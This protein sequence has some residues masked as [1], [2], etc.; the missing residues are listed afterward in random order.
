MTDELLSVLKRLPPPILQA[1]VRGEQTFGAI[2]EV[3]I[4]AGR[5]LS[6]T[7]VEGGFNRITSL[8]TD[9][10]MVAEAVA[11]LC[12]RSLHSHMDTIREGYIALPG[13]VRVGVAG[14]AVCEDGSICNVSQITSLCI[15]IPAAVWGVGDEVFREL[16]RRGFR[17][18]FLFYSPP[19]VGKTTLLRDLARSLSETAGLRVAVIDSRSELAC[20]EL[21]RADHIDLY[22]G[23]PKGKAIE[24][25]TRTMNPQY[26][27]CDEI[28]TLDEALA[29]LAVENAGVPLLASAHAGDIDQLLRRQNIRLLH[30]A[31][32]FDRYVGLSRVA[33]RL[34]F[35]YHDREILPP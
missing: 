3:R 9:A 26:I 20:E 6:L 22:S 32:V 19:G 14:K 2:C 24:L 28:G 13:G 29:L 33:D 23:Y 31:R 8:C 15:R 4:R 16:R 21:E 27:V 17:E 18:S 1:V 25:A 34:R 35:R 7:T 30:R 10:A 11:S 5:R 12:D